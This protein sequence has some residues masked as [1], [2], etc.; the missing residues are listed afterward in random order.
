MKYF[1]LL[2]ALLCVYLPAYAQTPVS[3]ERADEYLANCLKQPAVPGLSESG[4]QT[5]CACTAARLPVY[6]TVEDWNAMTGPDTNTARPAY[7]KMMTDV[8][9]PCMEEPTREKYYALCAENPSVNQEVCK[10][11]ADS[12]A[13]YMKNNGGKV[14]GE[15][16]ARNPMTMDPMAELENNTAFATYKEAA[17]RNCIR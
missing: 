8:Y 16:L 7:N 5:V 2:T 4:K 6:F 15:I 10:C 13:A 14:F 9:A 1:I 12:I 3:K 17:A 11:T